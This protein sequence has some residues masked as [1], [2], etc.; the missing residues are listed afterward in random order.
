M[1]ALSDYA[2]LVKTAIKEEID[3]IISGAGLP[4]NLPS[5]F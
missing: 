4:L 3:L 1:V 5:F 2:E